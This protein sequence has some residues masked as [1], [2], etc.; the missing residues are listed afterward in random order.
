[1]DRA[2]PLKGVPCPT[3]MD[4]KLRFLDFGNL[5]SLRFPIEPTLLDQQK[6]G[7]HIELTYVSFLS[8]TVAWSPS[9]EQ[10]SV[11][12][13]EKR[14]SAL[15]NR[16]KWVPTAPFGPKRFLNGFLIIYYTSKGG[17]P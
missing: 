5:L 17:P 4:N 14:V 9:Y 11:K 7:R 10:K 12:T 13:I 16:P 1:M 6:A 3:G 2:L 15:R 8:H